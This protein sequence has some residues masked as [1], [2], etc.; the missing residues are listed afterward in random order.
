[1]DSLEERLYKILEVK[2]EE[3]SKSHKGGSVYPSMVGKCIKYIVLKMKGVESEPIAGR[4]LLIM[5]NGNYVHERLEK[6]L[7]D[8]DILIA[9]ELS[10]KSKELNISGRSDA[11]IKNI[12]DNHKS[13]KI[14]TL[15]S[16]DEKLVYEGPEHDIAIVEL[17]SISSSG[18]DHVCKDSHP[19]YEHT[20]QL[21]LY[22]ELTGIHAGCILY[23]N[24][25][26]QQLR[27]FMF[28]MIKK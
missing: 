15:Y 19:K 2:N 25:N 21:M 1:M 12:L 3:R 16:P 17:K 9:P 23:E 24:K 5:E 11:I 13:N 27:T 20:M 18:F 26:T 22:E 14:V 6:M 8:C 7:G 4:S 28:L 10:I